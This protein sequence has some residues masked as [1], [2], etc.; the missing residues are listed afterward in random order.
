M[1]GRV[2]DRCETTFGIRTCE[3]E[4]RRSAD[5]IGE[6]IELKGGCMHH[7]NGNSWLCTIT[8]LR[9]GKWSG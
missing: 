6:P 7:D 2:V 9:S 8:G 3:L 1:A 4:Q 5:P